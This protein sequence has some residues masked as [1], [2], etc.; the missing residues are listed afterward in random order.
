[1]PRLFDP[2]RELGRT[3]FKATTIGLGDVADRA[4]PMDDCVATLRRG[5]DAGVNV[6][7]TAPSYENGYSEEI[8]GR[9][10][11]GL[12]D[13]VFVIDK[14]DFY[15]RPVGPQVDNSLRL[16]ALESV[17]LFVFHALSSMERW[18]EVVKPGGMMDELDKC[19]KAGK[20]R[21][22]GISS[23]H[24]LVVLEAIRS[25]LC[26]V[27][28]YPIGAFV[29]ASYIDAVLP[30]A[31]SRGVGTVCFKTFG[32]GKL[33]AGLPERNRQAN[34]RP[35]GKQSSGG[36]DLPPSD[37]P[38]LTVEECVGYTLTADPDV[39]LLGMSFPNEQDAVFRVARGFKPLAP[40]EM[41]RIR[42]KADKVMVG[43]GPFWWNSGG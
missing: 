36:A 2:R 10:V 20:C 16:L 33:L 34:L 27:V 41:K 4:V 39:A 29:D 6:I 23:H 30:E 42:D 18:R 31:R 26:D 14:I 1:M 21:F 28:M 37:E 15:D 13:Q 12:R 38:A 25:G 43:R 3:G 8:V 32:A 40:D 11:K 22:R 5:L 17:D 24:P 19:R 9:A 7:D 35:R